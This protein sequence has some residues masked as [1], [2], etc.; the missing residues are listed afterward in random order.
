M[1]SNIKFQHL[2][3]YI[4]GP[5]MIVPLGAATKQIAGQKSFPRAGDVLAVPE[6]PPTIETSRTHQAPFIKCACDI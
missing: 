2:H 1:L 5:T 6:I 3:I 4:Y